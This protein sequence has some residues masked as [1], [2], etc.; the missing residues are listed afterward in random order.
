MKEFLANIIL[1]FVWAA[2]NENFGPTNLGIGL[3]LGFAVLWLAQPMTGESRYFAKVGHVLAFTLFFIKEMVIANLRMA[4]NVLS[5]SV[6]LDPGVVAVPLD[7]KT[8]LEITL[9]ANF[10]TLTPGSFSLDVS[11][12]RRIL[13]VHAMNV[14]DPVQ[15][16]HEIK[17]GFERRLLEVLR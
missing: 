17:E 16:R 9:L 5:P 7:A 1:A 10:I 13:Y 6:K 15:F 2:L 11:D 4:R 3:G 8:D 12:D 14:D